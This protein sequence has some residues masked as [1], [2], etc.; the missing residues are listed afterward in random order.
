MSGLFDYHAL[1]ERLRLPAD[2]LARLEACVRGQYG[3]DEMM[4]ELR[5]LRT[6]RAIEERVTTL[7]A[8][9][10]EFGS[11]SV[12]AFAGSAEPDGPHRLQQH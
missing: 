10:E 8:A 2:R 4:F 7:D 9:I 5:M 1:V 6:L 11:N 3:S 12:R